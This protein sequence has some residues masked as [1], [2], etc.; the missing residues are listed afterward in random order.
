MGINT[1]IHPRRYAKTSKNRKICTGSDRVS[2]IMEN[3]NTHRRRRQ[4][5][6]GQ[7]SHAKIAAAACHTV[8]QDSGEL[9]FSKTATAHRT[10]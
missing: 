5:Q 7:L 8:R 6:R 10:R 2:D 4:G 1:D 3:K 9:S